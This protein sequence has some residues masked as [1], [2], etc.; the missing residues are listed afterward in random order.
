M[1]KIT[2]RGTGKTLEIGPQR[3]GDSCGIC[4]ANSIDYHIGAPLFTH[5]EDN[6]TTPICCQMVDAIRG[7]GIGI[8][9]NIRWKSTEYTR[10]ERPCRGVAVNWEL[11]K[12]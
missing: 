1:F 10:H 9:R 2:L 7:S 6:S 5:T 3:D 4:V 8:E 12:H 11:S